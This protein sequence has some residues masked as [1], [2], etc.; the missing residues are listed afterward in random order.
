ML[1]VGRDGPWL[2]ALQLTSQ[3]HDRDAAQEARHGRLWMDVGTGA[4]D[5]RKRPSE[6][7]LNRVIR[8]D[9][10]AVRRE[11]AVMD[12]RTFDRVARAMAE[13]RR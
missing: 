8:V 13:A 6:V 5:S 11:G 12:R 9:P 10:R 1:L 3:D 7:R 2:L 4:W